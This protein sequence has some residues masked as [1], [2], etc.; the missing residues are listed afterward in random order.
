VLS[1][2]PDALKYDLGL[3]SGAAGYLYTLLYIEGQVKE[4]KE[5]DRTKLS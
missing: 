2:S 4:L 5:L 1:Y 3:M